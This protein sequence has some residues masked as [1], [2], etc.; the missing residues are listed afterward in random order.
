MLIC[1][2]TTSKISLQQS[3]Y[4]SESFQISAHCVQNIVDYKYKEN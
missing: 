2:F 3:L 1:Q 4:R